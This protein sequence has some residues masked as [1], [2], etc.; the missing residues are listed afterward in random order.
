MKCYMGEHV[1]WAL[2]LG[3][4]FILIAV[5]GLP[6]LAF[7][8]LSKNSTN[9]DS[10][11]VLK[12]YGFLFRGYRLKFWYWE[13]I[14]LI[15]KLALAALSVFMVSY[16]PYVQGLSAL[17]IVTMVRRLGGSTNYKLSTHTL[18]IPLNHPYTPSYT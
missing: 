14:I 9:L 4:P 15:R 13:G 11:D 6:L 1:L 5:I 10:P 18:D 7:S 8:T 3:V 17:F 12:K 16:S 2:Y